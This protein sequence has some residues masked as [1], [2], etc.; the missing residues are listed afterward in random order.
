MTIGRRLLI[1]VLTVLMVLGFGVGWSR[2]QAVENVRILM[3][4]PFVDATASLVDRFNADH[5]D[6]IHLSITRGPLETESISD[7][8]ISS[9]LLGEGADRLAFQIEQLG[10]I[11]LQRTRCRGRDVRLH[12][13]LAQVRIRCRQPPALSPHEV[14]DDRRG[15]PAA[16]AHAVH[17]DALALGTSALDG[18]VEF[19]EW[20]ALAG[21]RCVFIAILVQVVARGHQVEYVRHRQD[22]EQVRA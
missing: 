6:R 19:R 12:V 17:E 18:L 10:F 8:A 22:L 4:D 1:M 5:Q 9:L 2:G 20:P 21:R 14:S 16:P 3:P 15:A 13:A 11:V 7:L